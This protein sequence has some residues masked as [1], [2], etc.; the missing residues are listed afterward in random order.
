MLITATSQVLHSVL[1][2]HQCFSVFLSL[3]HLVAWCYMDQYVTARSG[4]AVW[5][6]N[7][8]IQNF[9]PKTWRE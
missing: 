8:C 9:S 7:K 3:T 6:H 5:G 4:L 2:L 1:T